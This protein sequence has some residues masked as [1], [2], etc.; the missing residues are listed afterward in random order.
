VRL[1]EQG[2]DEVIRVLQGKRPWYVV[3]PEVLFRENS[4]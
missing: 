4:S 2:M 3:N 1:R